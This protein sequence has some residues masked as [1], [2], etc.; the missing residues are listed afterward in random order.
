MSKGGLA[1]GLVVAWLAAAALTAPAGAADEKDD[2]E[3]RRDL[4]TVITLEGHP[5]GA[6]VEAQRLGPDDYLAACKTGDRY[7]VRI[8]PGDRLSVEKQ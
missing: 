4:F 2:A 6:V 1:L 8:K 5:C 3:V 7:R